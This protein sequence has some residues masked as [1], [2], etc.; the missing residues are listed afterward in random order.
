MLKQKLN[1]SE[2]VS[3]LEEKG[4]LF[5]EYSKENAE[6]YLRDKNSFFRIKAYAKN[7]TKNPKTG[8]YVNLDFAYL[9]EFA[10][11]DF[12]LRKLILS[13]SID[14]EHSL[15]LILLRHFN[16]NERED[17]YTIIEDF[18]AQHPDPDI[19]ENICNKKS[20]Y[21]KDLIDKYQNNFSL[22]NIIEVLSFGDFLRLFQLYFDKYEPRNKTYKHYASL[23]QSVRILRNATAHNTCLLNT[24]AN[25][26]NQKKIFINILKKLGQQERK[27]FSKVTLLLDFSALLVLFCHICQSKGLYRARIKELFAFL[28]RC[29]KHQDYFQKEQLFTSRFKAIQKFIVILLKNKTNSLIYSKS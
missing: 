11:L 21:I 27:H 2:Q 29:K 24:F 1:F 12:Y 25:Q 7:Y 18:F 13:F 10:T 17:G 23:A 15:K 26:N 20:G 6:I 14:I 8:K 9:K 16:D 4:I 22:W 5:K 28:K 3:H 19:R